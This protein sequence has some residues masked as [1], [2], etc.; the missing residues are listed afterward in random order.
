MLN[1][2]R[3]LALRAVATQGSI[4]AAAETL[5]V[6]TSAVSQQLAKLEREVG[7]PLLER[8]GRGVRLT[9]AGTV[10]I[11]YADRAMSV[12]EQA[13]AELDARRNTVAGPITIAVFA[14]AARGLAPFAIS[15]LVNR[16]R[17]IDVHL[18]EH[19]PAESI[20][21][22][23][24]RDVD[25]VIAVDWFNAPL[26]MPEGLVK[27]PLMDDLADIALPATHRLAN[28]P[29][30]DLDAI[31]AESWIS[32]PS[33][34]ICHD[35][36]LHTLRSRG[37]EPRISH[38]ANE[39]ATQVALV[40]AGLGAAV[41]PRLGRDPVPEG[42]KM[43]ASNPTLH[44]HVYAI[45]RADATRRTVIRAAVKAFE[46]ATTKLAELPSPGAQRRSPAIRPAGASRP[47]QKK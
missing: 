22:L 34:S 25:L 13:E 5:H 32:Y 45:W 30:V 20:P 7:Q 18:R 26:A 24:R 41:I 46:A 2:D 8:N 14:T 1:L 6:T 21:L 16:Y 12:I 11:A 40:A 43:V 4:N 31:A 29:I 3:L 44:R 38:Y 39:H 9:D 33:N 28:R 23:A 35:W 27:A 42:V 17:D 19:D 15:D 37:H 36:L 10:L 47:R